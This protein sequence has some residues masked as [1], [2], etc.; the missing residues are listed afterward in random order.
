MSEKDVV[1]HVTGVSMSGGVKNDSNRP[2]PENKSKP[3]AKKD[4]NRNEYGWRANGWPS[5]VS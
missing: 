4:W 1:V 5:I 3:E 2:A